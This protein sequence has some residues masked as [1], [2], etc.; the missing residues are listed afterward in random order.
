[1]IEFRAYTPGEHILFDET[2]YE[3]VKESVTRWGS[4]TY[5]IREL[6]SESNKRWLTPA[7]GNAPLRVVDRA[8]IRTFVEVF[9][10]SVAL[11][12]E[13]GPIF[14]RRVHGEW[15]PHLDKMVTFW[16]AVLL[17]EMGY[18]GQPPVVHRAIE[19]LKPE[20]FGR[21]LALFEETMQALFEPHLAE[22]LSTKSQGIAQML[23]TAVFGKPWDA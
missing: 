3:V 15:G 4:P 20:H 5:L 16:S 2:L 10:R 19:E 23:S 21:W 7:R 9:Y 12:P 18:Q 14:E 8:A 1:M 17:R 6:G 11:D 13:L 22:Y